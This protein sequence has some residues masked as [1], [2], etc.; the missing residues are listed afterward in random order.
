MARK[1]DLPEPADTSRS[2]SPAGSQLPPSRREFHWYAS[3][4]GLVLSAGRPRLGDILP[5]V[6]WH[7]RGSNTAWVHDRRRSH[8][9]DSAGA[10]S[11]HF[12]AAE[13]TRSRVF[14]DGQMNSTLALSTAACG[15]RWMRAASG[16]RCS[17]ASPWRRSARLQWPRRRQTPSTSAAANPRCAIQPALATA[18]TSRRTPARRGR[19]SALRARITLAGSRSIPGIRTSPSLPRSDNSMRPIP[20]ADSFGQL[21]AARPGRKCLA[22][23]MS[24]PPKS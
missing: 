10:C 24:A 9:L 11:G 3:Q 5:G 19:T 16:R 18:S 12:A 13:P 7:A 1:T 8:M 4:L 2:A 6:A 17:T 14:P 21:T 15:S 23:A 20:S 22:P